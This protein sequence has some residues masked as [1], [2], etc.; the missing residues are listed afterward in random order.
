MTPRGRCPTP[1]RPHRPGG[2]S[3]RGVGHDPTGRGPD[4]RRPP[5][6]R[7]WGPRGGRRLPR[8]RAARPLPRRTGRRVRRGGGGQLLRRPGGRRGRAPRCRRTSIRDA[9]SGSPAGSTLGCA[10]ARPDATCCCSIPTPRSRPTVPHP[11]PTPTCGPTRAWP[12]SPRPST[13]RSTG[14]TPGWA[15]PSRPRRG[16]GWRPP[17]WAGCAGGPD[18]LIGSVLLLADRALSDTGGFDDRFFLYAEE[19]DWQRRA[20]DRG[21]RVALCPEVDRPPTSGP[22]P[23]GTPRHAR[24]TSR[25]PTNA[26]CASH[27]GR[28]GWWSYR[29]A[30]VVGSG[31]APWSCPVP[32]AGTP[33]CA[34]ACSGRGPLRAEAEL[35]RTG[36]RIAHVVVTDAFA[37]VER[38]V[39][40]VA[41]GLAD[42]GHQVD[43][44]GGDPERMRAELDHGRGRT[45]PARRSAPATRAL[46][47]ARRRPRPRPHDG[48]RGRPPSSPAR[49]M[50]AP[51]WRPGTSP[52]NGGR[53]A[54][55]GRS[56]GSPPPPL[57][58]DI[59]ISEFVA[60]T[61]GGPTTLI[62]NGVAGRGPRPRWTLPVVVMLQRL[63]HEKA[64][65][66]GIRAWAASGLGGR[67][68]RAGGRRFGRPAR[69][70]SSG[71]GRRA[72][73]ARRA[74][75]F[76]GQVADTDGLLAGVVDPARPGP[77]EPFGLSVVEAMSHGLAVVA[78]A[79]GAHVE[80]VG[81]RRC[82]VPAR[83]PT[84][85]PPAALAR[86]ADDP[87]A[88]PCRRRRPA[89]PP[90]GALLARAPPRPARVPLPERRRT[91]PAR[92]PP[93]VAPR[94]GSHSRSHAG[95]STRS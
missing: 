76:A 13:T 11:P 61:V 89:V 58:A 86:L 18:F 92:R 8:G 84:A 9:T 75:T 64:P 85:R 44:I 28:L 77:G 5:T 59:A 63:D 43:V 31:R 74:S 37:G 56:P 52:P 3:D 51:S 91:V 66:V 19:T 39:C 69:P 40:Q 71:A 87:D 10:P 16:P 72:R 4:R 26:T 54:A 83:R 12:P 1:A 27:H 81:S 30:G 73:A 6:V 14:R 67:G 78:A 55:T 50:R 29:L 70:G 48:G 17:A 88:T 23:V 22:E 15:G 53:P 57:A 38:Y 25:R 41:N 33:P 21:W 24:P 7:R 80:T 35:G 79:G 62:P 60:D 90:A 47:A 36:L 32:G 34:C 42:R 65:D 95:R 49:S 45:G 2:T 93:G 94:S 82:A 46:A 68:W 20:A